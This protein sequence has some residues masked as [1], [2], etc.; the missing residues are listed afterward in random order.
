MG[1]NVVLSLTDIHTL[2]P[3][4]DEINRHFFEFPGY[5]VA[6]AGYGSKEKYRPVLEN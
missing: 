2:H 6:D 4:L 3:F 5:L 1:Y